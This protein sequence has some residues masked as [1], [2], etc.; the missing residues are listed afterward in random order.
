MPQICDMGH[1]FT[2]SPKE[3]MLW[4]ELTWVVWSYFILKW[5]EVKWYTVNLGAKSAR[6]SGV[7]YILRV[8]DC[9][10]PV[11]FGVYLVLFVSTCCVM[12]GYF[13]NVYLYVLCFV[14]LVLCFLYCLVYVYLFLFVLW[15]TVTKWQLICS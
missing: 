13:V 14:L 11:S 8:R 9:I 7:N 6:C 1:G 5:S 2:P 12:C 4:C 3:G 10:G 15:T